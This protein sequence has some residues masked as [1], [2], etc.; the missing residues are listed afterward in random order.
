MT[1]TY[2]ISRKDAADFLW[3]STRTVDRYVKKGKL[4]YKKVSNNVLL[5]Q[6]ELDTMK[7]DLDLV[8]QNTPQSTRERVS[9]WTS[10][11]DSKQSLSQQ[12]WSSKSGVSEFAEILDKKD[13]TIEE[14]NQLIFMLQRK[15]WEVETQ[16]RNMVALPDHTQ[17]KNQLEEQIDELTNTT[18]K[19]KIQV[20]KEK[21]RNAIY[22]G[23][24][25]IAWLAVFM[26]VS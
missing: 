25:I 16:M 17:E 8:N 26:L 24:V 22:M 12:G 9:S 15:I 2:N 20:R 19:L 18:T 1:L 14:K 4:S 23:L 5:A 21:M 6:D 13:Q 11:S 10:W 7:K 3:V